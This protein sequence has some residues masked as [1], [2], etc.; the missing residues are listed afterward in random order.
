MCAELLLQEAHQ[1][2]VRA[3][4]RLLHGARGDL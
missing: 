4:G 1:M 2:L 3:P